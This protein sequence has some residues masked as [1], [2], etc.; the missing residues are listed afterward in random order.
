[1]VPGYAGPYKNWKGKVLKADGSPKSTYGSEKP[2]KGAKHAL[3]EG[4]MKP[5][6]LKRRK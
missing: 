3:E 4:T 1:M 6:K 2:R 5:N